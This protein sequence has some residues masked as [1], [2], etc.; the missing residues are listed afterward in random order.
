MT[1]V[2][3]NYKSWT[4][5]GILA[6]NYLKC[7]EEF[8][9]KR[10][11]DDEW[12][13]HIKYVFLFLKE[14]GIPENKYLKKFIKGL[15]PAVK[16]RIKL[17]DIFETFFRIVTESPQDRQERLKAD[18]LKR[19]ANKKPWEGK[20]EDEIRTALEKARKEKLEQLE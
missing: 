19:L 7:Q 9:T 18:N 11:S 5:C 4:A 16:E 1:T 8:H 2:S 20:S 13:L 3:Y 15:K 12:D 10:I 14:G 6:F 17:A